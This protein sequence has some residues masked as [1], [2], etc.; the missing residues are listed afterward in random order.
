[1]YESNVPNVLKLKWLTRDTLDSVTAIFWQNHG[2]ISS[3]EYHA[4]SKKGW[5]T[6]AI[7]NFLFNDIN[8]GNRNAISWLV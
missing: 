1:M 5:K 7:L 8:G 3:S 6:V 2:G 4:S